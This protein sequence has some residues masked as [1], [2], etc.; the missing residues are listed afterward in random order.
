MS[1][2]RSGESHS[3]ESP[4]DFRSQIMNAAGIT[5]S[6]E[7]RENE[8]FKK[9]D[10]VCL[11]RETDDREGTVRVQLG[12]ITYI[13]P[14]GDIETENRITPMPNIHDGNIEKL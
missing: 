2:K 4:R 6:S 12:K 8:P 5:S 13:Y 7:I 1:K 11:I 3:P 14:N 10:E 9:G